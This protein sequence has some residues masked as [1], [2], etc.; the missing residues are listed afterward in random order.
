MNRPFNYL[1]ISVIV[2]IIIGSI[3]H[4]FIDGYLLI[5]L[6][7]LLLLCIVFFPKYSLAY[8]CI[9]FILLSNYNFYYHTKD[10]TILHSY[11]GKHL[12]LE[13]RIQ[14]IGIQ[15][16]GYY[17]YD[18]KVFHLITTDKVIKINEKTKIQI[19]NC[20]TLETSLKPGDGL[21]LKKALL[22][23]D[24]S[25][26]TLTGYQ[27]YL[28]GKGIKNI[29]KVD[30]KDI[31]IKNSKPWNLAKGS[32]KTKKYIEDFFDKS[33]QSVQSSLIKSIAFGNQ[34]YLDKD[35]L[36]LFSITGT[37]H[38]IAVSGL[39]V[40]VLVLILHYVLKKL[41]MGKNQVLL[42]T[43]II[44][45][46]YAYMVGFPVSIIRANCMYYLYVGGYFLERRYDAINSLM[47]MA[48]V[49]LLYNPFT[50]F[51][52]SFQLSFA[53]TLSI[54]LFYPILKGYLKILPKSLQS[55][56]GVTLAAQLGTIPIMIYHF[57]QVSIVSPLANIFI[58]PTL[59][60]LL[61]MGF[62]SVIASVFSRN[63]GYTI[64]F[65]TNGLLTYIYRAIDICSKWKFA[66]IEIKDINYFYIILY[67]LILFITY[68][69]LR[70][71]QSNQNRFILEKE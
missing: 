31:I 64:N 3:F 66:N 16:E 7:F 25:E 48:F 39:H 30:A 33:L 11:T 69:I 27:V 61:S 43:M 47:L 5:G 34:G 22:V 58:V 37:A 62:F 1:C 14:G 17:E 26:N 23:E 44:L 52:V 15:R 18:M 20:N 54:L 67:Y 55:L 56:L 49:L 40:G 63:L 42:T 53:A 51:S 65:I 29:L 12:V 32:Y 68:F 46:L 10:I 28:R 71:K 13:G 21:I 59:V 50:L 9:S 4:I 36:S 24:F 8:V 60:P 19:K 38:I 2:G 70:R 41:N 6:L 57:G 45:F 35:S